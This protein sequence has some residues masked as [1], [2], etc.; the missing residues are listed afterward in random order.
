MLIVT[1][2]NDDAELLSPHDLHQ[3]EFREVMADLVSQCAPKKVDTIEV[4]PNTHAVVIRDGDK[5]VVAGCFL[6][7]VDNPDIRFVVHL[8]GVLP[9]SRGKGLGPKLSKAVE[10]AV[11]HLRKNEYCVVA[12][13][14][15]IP[16]G[17]F[18]GYPV[19]FEMDDVD[20]D[21]AFCD[22]LPFL[23]KMGYRQFDEHYNFYKFIRI[24]Q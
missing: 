15:C 2:L 18:G 22:F 20:M 17:S 12:G 10:L 8:A 11:E 9:A 3:A 19:V 23:T 14:E 4:F 1:R 6:D 7:Y 5:K 13:F 21:E 24:D 16:V